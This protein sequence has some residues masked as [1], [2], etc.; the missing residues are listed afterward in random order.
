MRCVIFSPMLGPLI[1]SNVCVGGG[2]DCDDCKLHQTW[3]ALKKPTSFQEE[4]ANSPFSLELLLPVTMYAV[5]LLLCAAA[6]KLYLFLLSFPCCI[7]LRTYSPARGLYFTKGASSSNAIRR[8]T[9]LRRRCFH[10]GSWEGSG[11]ELQRT[12]PA[13]FA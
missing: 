8:P 11:F 12:I 4:S 10:A 5:F 9:Q 3:S 6:K 13:N 1:T 7:E 2:G